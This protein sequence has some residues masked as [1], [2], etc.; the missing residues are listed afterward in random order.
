VLGVAAMPQGTEIGCRSTL[1][2]QQYISATWASRTCSDWYNCATPGGHHYP[3]VAVNGWTSLGQ[4]LGV[5]GLGHQ[6]L[7]FAALA[8]AL[9]MVAMMALA[10]AVAVPIG[11]LSASMREWCSRSLGVHPSESD[12]RGP[13]AAN[14]PL[15]AGSR[16]QRER[17]MFALGVAK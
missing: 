16:Q 1:N 11:R 2:G 8:F 14:L 3:M 13:Q 17:V 7:F 12:R 9:W 15:T 6:A 5:A 4:P 10:A